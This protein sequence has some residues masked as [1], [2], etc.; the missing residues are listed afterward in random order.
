MLRSLADNPKFTVGLD[1]ISYVPLHPARER[2]RGY[3]QAAELAREI[4]GPLGL[5]LLRGAVDRSR[6][7]PPQVGLNRPDRMTNVKGAFAT[8]GSC[9]VEGL[10][11]LLV[12]D[13]MTTGA[14]ANECAREL[15]RA[16]AREVRVATFARG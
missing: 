7:T 13:V 2:E 6:S 10:A 12:D 9:Q 1:A 3:N 11:L 8:S 4:A 14:T 5:P 16:G 15:L